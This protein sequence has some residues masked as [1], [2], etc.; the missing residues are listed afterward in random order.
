MVTRPPAS[1]APWSPIARRAVDRGARAGALPEDD[2]PWSR[3]ARRPA[4]AP[5][6]DASVRSMPPVIGSHSSTFAG[7]IAEPRA[8]GARD[9]AR[10]RQ[11]I[12]VRVAQAPM[13]EADGRLPAGSSATSAGSAA[14]I[15]C[16]RSSPLPASSTF[17]PPAAYSA[18]QRRVASG[19]CVTARHHDQPVPARAAPRPASRRRSDRRCGRRRESPGR[20]PG[21]RDR[22]CRSSRFRLRPDPG[23]ISDHASSVGA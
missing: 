21:R 19:M 18:S 12:H 9:V 23:L 14:A 10:V 15:R 22:G 4:S 3:E 16:C 11:E 13:D 17:P 2:D 5:S 8:H 1:A 6:P 20:S 7:P